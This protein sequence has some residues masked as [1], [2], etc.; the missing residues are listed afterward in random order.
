MKAVKRCPRC[1]SSVDLPHQ[2]DNDC[3]A[4]VDREL[5]AAVRMLRD[6][7]RRKSKL[8]RERIRARQAAGNYGR[9]MRGRSP[10][11]LARRLSRLKF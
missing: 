5:A 11:P 9:D 3:F 1:Q 10:S 2:T 8:I 7:T 6:L 4:V